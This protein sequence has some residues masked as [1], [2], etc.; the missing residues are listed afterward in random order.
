MV[1]T[2]E[3]RGR[4]GE[5]DRGSD[6]KDA[7]SGRCSQNPPYTALPAEGDLISVFRVCCAAHL[8]AIVLLAVSVELHPWMGML[9]LKSDGRLR[10]P[11]ACATSWL[12]AASSDTGV[13]PPIR[14]YPLR[15]HAVLEIDSPSPQIGRYLR[16]ILR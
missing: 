8:A 5:L 7:G 4:V 14:P 12:S 15:P 10:L 3:K 6:L 13:P 1:G 9:D 11:L 16:N 2:D